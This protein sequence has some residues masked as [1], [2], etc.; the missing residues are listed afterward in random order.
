MARAIAA[1]V[2]VFT[3]LFQLLMRAIGVL[4]P[5]N[6]EAAL[7]REVSRCKRPAPAT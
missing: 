4:G 5:R 2:L 1:L 6:L 7:R 3:E